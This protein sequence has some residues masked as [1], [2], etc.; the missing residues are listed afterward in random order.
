MFLHTLLRILKSKV[1]S[2]GFNDDEIFLKLF[3][4]FQDPKSGED[5]YSE[6]SSLRNILSGAR[7]VKDSLSKQLTTPDGFDLLQGNIEYNYIP[8]IEN[9]KNLYSSLL[10]R[11]QKSKYV[12][13]THK[14]QIANQYTDDYFSDVS[15]A[16]LIALC[17]LIGNYN[18]SV[19]CKLGKCESET[20]FK[21]YELNISFVFGSTS[22]LRER[23]WHCSQQS[24]FISHKKGNRFAALNIIERLLP[25]GY[26]E[27][28]IMDF[29]FDSSNHDLKTIDDICDST[30]DNI[31]ITGEGGIG[32]TT[33]MQKVL[34]RTFGSEKEPKEYI[35]S[36]PIPIFIELNRCPKEIGDWY[37]DRY[38]KTNFITRY[39]VDSIQGSEHKYRDY[40]SL[41]DKIET[42]FR[43]NPYN[44]PKAYL[45]LLDGFNEVSTG[46]GTNGEA[47][48]AS[49]SHEINELRKL[50]NVRIITTSRVTQSAYYANNF[51][52]VHL[53][54]LEEPD[55]K[56]HLSLNG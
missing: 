44:K 22:L 53:N 21:N 9:K 48:R 20:F 34:E 18:S 1:D 38:Q 36:N 47:I 41:L 46:M 29:H 23:I 28:E 26:I 51:T 17:I 43:T 27:P 32:K 54:G 24:Y 2:H 25:K 14:R 4:G 15:L 52:R 13:D 50:P 42:E 6:E 30:L 5:I 7:A 56:K 11:I 35:S 37:D 19:K 40:S 55:I 8:L 12:L 16:S 49:L 10:D 31:A 39:I 45:L 3:E 33:F